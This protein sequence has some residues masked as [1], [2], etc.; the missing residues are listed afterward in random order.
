VPVEED[1]AE[2]EDI[3]EVKDE[4]MDNANGIWGMDLYWITYGIPSIDT[5]PGAGSLARSC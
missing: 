3:N 2:A 4:D 1:E 5:D